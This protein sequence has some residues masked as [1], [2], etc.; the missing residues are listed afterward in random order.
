MKY[1]HVKNSY[2]WKES[3]TLNRCDL[4]VVDKSQGNKAISFRIC[5][6]YVPGV[7]MQRRHPWRWQSSSWRA[8]C[9]WRF[10]RM[11]FSRNTFRTPRVSSYM[12]PEIR[13]TPPRRARRR[14][15]GLVIP[16]VL[17]R[18]PCLWCLEPPFPSLFPP[19]PIPFIVT[20]VPNHVNIT[21]LKT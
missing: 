17:S 8:R 6:G 1:C 2:F 11:T 18:C 16:C 15:A 9:R 14:M 13:L 19:L 10:S 12:R 20:S 21:T 5:T 7:S 4:W 3:W